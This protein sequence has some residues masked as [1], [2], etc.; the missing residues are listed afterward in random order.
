M[1]GPAT[2]S[3]TCACP[4]C[5]VKLGPRYRSHAR[6]CSAA[7]RARAARATREGSESVRTARSL[8]GTGKAFADGTKQHDGFNGTPARFAVLRMTAEE[9][10]RRR[11]RWHRWVYGSERNPIGR[12]KA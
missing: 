1:T 3:R 11:P 7:C 5:S 6:Y 4:G 12:R 10:E 9:A 2:K 8:N